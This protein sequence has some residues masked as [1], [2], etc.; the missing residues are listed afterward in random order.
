MD[1]IWFRSSRIAALVAVIVLCA[2]PVRP[3]ETAAPAAA[4]PAPEPAIVLARLSTDPRTPEGY[5]G[6]LEIHVK[7][8]SFPFIG[9]TV[10][11]TSSYRKPGLYHYQLQNLPRVAAKFD[12]LRY[13]LGDP[14][15]WGARY[16][17]AMAPQSN[18][19]VPVLR[20]TPKKP[21]G[22]VAYLDIETDAKHARMI[23]ATWTRHDGGTIVLTQ[24][25]A[26]LGAADVVTQQHATIDIPHFRAELT[27]TYTDL[28]LDTPTF[29]GVSDR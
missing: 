22:Q 25:Y 21:G 15:S 27:A 11:G 17:I 5:S 18:D 6:K 19:E 28:T 23:K 2:S 26:A 9:L 12:D 7:M 3:E 16:D 24:T 8:H 4:A 29:A 10:H 13:D 14:S 20:L 1:R